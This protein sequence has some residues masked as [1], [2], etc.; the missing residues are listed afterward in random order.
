MTHEGTI[1]SPLSGVQRQFLGLAGP[2]EPEVGEL[3]P[4]DISGAAATPEQLFDVARIAGLTAIGF[5]APG[6]L[7]QLATKIPGLL[8][9]ISSQPLTNLLGTVAAEFEADVLAEQAGRALGVERRTPQQ[10]KA[11]RSFAGLLGTGL[12]LPF[13]L[14]QSIRRGAVQQLA[15]VGVPDEIV[16]RTVER[17]GAG[18]S[19]LRF[20]DKSLPQQQQIPKPA[21][22]GQEVSRA[23]TQSREEATRIIQNIPELADDLDA[24]IETRF[25]FFEEIPVAPAAPAGE[26]IETGLV[27]VRELP[28]VTRQL[29]GE[30]AAPLATPRRPDLA[31]RAAG[32]GLDDVA[33][34]NAAVAFEGVSGRVGMMRFL[35]Q[36]INDNIAAAGR[37]NV[38]RFRIVVDT[39]AEGLPRLL[40]EAPDA[41][42]IFKQATEPL[43]SV[44]DDINNARTIG[45]LTDAR[46]LLNQSIGGDIASQAVLR[47][48]REALSDLIQI[49]LPD[50]A[51][52]AFRRFAQ[53]SDANNIVKTLGR[54]AEQNQSFA[55]TVGTFDSKQVPSNTPL[56]P[57][58]IRLDEERPII[59]ALQT[60]FDSA[61]TGRNA[62]DFLDE[63]AG[64]LGAARAK[65]TTALVTSRQQVGGL[66]GTAA[67][68]EP[69]Q[70]QFGILA[71][72]G[73]LTGLSPQSAMRGLLTEAAAARPIAE[74]FPALGG[75]PGAQRP[76]RQ[77]TDL[78]RALGVTVGARV[79]SVEELNRPDLGLR[80]LQ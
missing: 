16:S 47:P 60:V 72:L 68:R 74:R 56:A 3:A 4:L 39:P 45:D 32:A 59:E 20:F 27:G 44:L 67:A 76:S 70:Q 29:P 75:L 53:V 55:K 28:E 9:R 5:T 23:L 73:A 10:A 77:A 6:R 24:A 12:G 57:E 36:Q 63:L 42:G 18:A 13:A 15:N 79:P 66:A 46:T 69:A 1:H 80:I 30:I 2:Q 58:T 34:A 31:V 35:S 43:Q 65:G 37:V 19:F 14:T 50:S 61:G 8:G 40:V 38:P 33:A 78:A 22:L 71:R 26:I 54:T 25:L 64:T 17:P 7:A 51:N 21:L 48:A 62:E 49:V 41:Q 52:A 11:E